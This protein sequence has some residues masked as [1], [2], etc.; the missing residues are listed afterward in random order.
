MNAA[1]IKNPPHPTALIINLPAADRESV[2]WHSEF[3]YYALS[4]LRFL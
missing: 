2:F 3:C 1:V 4:C